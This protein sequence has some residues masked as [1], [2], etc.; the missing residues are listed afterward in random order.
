HRSAAKT[1]PPTG[2]ISVPGDRGAASCVRITNG[3]PGLDR[4]LWR[5]EQDIGGNFDIAVLWIPLQPEVLI[6]GL[7]GYRGGN[8]EECSQCPDDSH[9]SSPRFSRKART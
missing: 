3:D 6:R 4:H 7:R 5:V 2:E 8:H 9:P 1:E